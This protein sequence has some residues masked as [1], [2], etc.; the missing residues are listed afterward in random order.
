MKS[1]MSFRAAVPA[2][3]LLLSACQSGPENLGRSGGRLDP[4]HDSPVEVGVL[5]LRSADLVTATDHMAQDIAGRL[6]I[7]NRSYPPR[8]VVGRIENRTGRPE[9]DYQVFL[10]R[11]RSQ[12][13]SSG[14]RHGLDFRRERGFVEQQ[15]AREYGVNDPQRSP[16][17]YRS[18]AEYVLT[19][20]IS[21]LPAGGTVYY[22]LDFQLVQLVDEAISGPD[23]GPGAIVWSGFHEVKYQ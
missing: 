11:L 2:V 21:D 3:L 15:R 13:L 20:V 4:T 10:G 1:L 23:V 17:L 5:D 8:I 22:H 9:Q 14:A 16:H 6:D 12:L 7:T 19:C 18:E